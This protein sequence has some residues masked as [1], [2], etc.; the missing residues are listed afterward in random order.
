MLNPTID[1]YLALRRAAGFQLGMSERHLR[2]FARFANA[3]GD[4]HVRADRAIEWAGQAPTP[5]QS[6]VRLDVI[7]IFVRYVRAEDPRHE[8]PPAHVFP[9][10]RPPLL[11]TIFTPEQITRL[12][13]AA[14]GLGPAQSH[15]P[16][17]YSTLFALLA[18]TGLRI[19]EALALQIGDVTPDGL[20]IRETKFRKSRLVP[21]HASSEVALREYFAHRFKVAGG[22]EHVFV[23]PSGHPLAYNTVNAVFRALVREIG[24][25]QVPGRRGPRIHDL[26]HTFAVRAL[27]MCPADR[28]RVAA[29]MLALSTYLGHAK[30][31]STYW[32]LHATPHLLVDIAD[33]C[34]GFTQRVVS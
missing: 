23:S 1:A 5:H 6:C 22:S 32:Y 8:P 7:R 15:R 2:S 25:C 24:L 12:L 4:S 31:V 3:H 17:T 13:T 20:L 19:S 30:L 16:R 33:A 28:L 29:H 18:A 26:R 9:R 10:T 21:L 11:P 27:E 14:A 34:E